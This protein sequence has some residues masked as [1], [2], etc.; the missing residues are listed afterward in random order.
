MRHLKRGRKLNRTSAHRK[1]MFRN[2]VT[3]LLEHER[4][5]TTVPK[6]KELRGV[7][8]RMITYAKKGTL[9]H[10]RLAARY[11]RNA[12]VLNRLFTEYAERYQ[13]RPG[14]YTRIMRL[15]PRRGDAAEMALIELMPE[16]PVGTGKRRRT[17]ESTED[18]AATAP[19]TS[20]ESF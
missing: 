18:E 20:K 3:S 10:R 5:M 12:D 11:V 9:H 13:E 17:V 6:A 1:A 15:G 7:A 14:G 19:V 2:M 4:I 8:D 16:G